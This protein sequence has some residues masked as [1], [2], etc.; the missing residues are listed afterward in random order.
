MVQALP[1]FG[2]PL[3]TAL[4]RSSVRTSSGLCV[5]G[6]LA[7]CFSEIEKNGLKVEGIF[8]KSGSTAIIN[9]LQK[10]FENVEDPFAL[11]LPEN[12]NGHSMAGLLKRYLQQLPEPVI[13]KHYQKQFLSAFED[14]DRYTKE[15]VEQRLKDA[16]K[17]LPY[18]HLHLLQFIIEIAVRIQRHQDKNQMSLNSLAIIFAPTCVRLD[19]VS[20]LMPS[21]ALVTSPSI[22][23]SASSSCSLPLTINKHHDFITKAR[24]LIVNVIKRK[25]GR[26]HNKNNWLYNKSSMSLILYQPSDLLQL[27]LMKES[28]T[29]VGLFEFMMNHPESFTTITQL[30]RGDLEKVIENQR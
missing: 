24:K 12:I 10:H 20:Q 13:P 17:Q 7:R 9:Q 6:I 25:M 16:C 14:K 28:N 3:V 26:Q 22:Q 19:G 21:S 18:E 11:T 29:W 8:R 1:L 30:K 15:T 27:D 5:P 2:S 23:D 4:A